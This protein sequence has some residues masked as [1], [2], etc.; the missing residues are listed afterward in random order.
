M[1]HIE[2][3]AFATAKASASATSRQTAP[4]QPLAK[5]ARRS[6]K[7]WLEA[8]LLAPGR[9][10]FQQ[11]CGG[12]TVT[13]PRAW[14]GASHWENSLKK[15]ELGRRWVLGESLTQLPEPCGLALKIAHC[16]QSAT[17]QLV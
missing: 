13:G 17:Q 11:G 6:L 10:F 8:R 5:K 12:H 15:A 16:A 3:R 2:K 1:S 9:Y 7:R 4:G 14:D